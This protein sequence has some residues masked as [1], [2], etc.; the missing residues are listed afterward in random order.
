MTK[1]AEFRRNLKKKWRD[2]KF[3]RCGPKT[4]TPKS[5]KNRRPRPP[6]DASRGAHTAVMRKQDALSGEHFSRRSNRGAR[7]LHP[8]C[9]PFLVISVPFILSTERTE[10]TSAT[11]VHVPTPPLRPLLEQSSFTVV[12]LDCSGRVRQERARTE[13]ASGTDVHTAPGIPVRKAATAVR[14]FRHGCRACAL[15]SRSLGRGNAHARESFP[16][17]EPPLRLLSARNDHR[18]FGARAHENTRRARL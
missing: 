4:V 6:H 1:I 12:E 8:R 18:P 16:E 17:R 2:R 5:C 10:T 3:W 14:P 13:A 15:G 11:D 9:A 7:C